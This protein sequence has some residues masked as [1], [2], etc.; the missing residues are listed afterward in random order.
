MGVFKDMVIVIE[1]MYEREMKKLKEMINE[2]LEDFRKNGT[3]N[4]DVTFEIEMAT[5]EGKILAFAE[6]GE[7]LLDDHTMLERHDK[8]VEEYAQNALEIIGDDEDDD[9]E[10]ET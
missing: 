8:L 4:E 1:E 6:I 10:E 9:L 5:C 7:K 2:S 3:N